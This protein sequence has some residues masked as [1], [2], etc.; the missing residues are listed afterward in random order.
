MSEAEFR[1]E[2]LEEIE[3]LQPDQ[4]ERL[5]AFARE[6]TVSKIPDGLSWEEMRKYRGIISREE[7]E[8][9]KKAIE[10]ECER[11]DPEGW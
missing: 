3:H 7:A 1:H 10:E 9:M 6:L 4:Q 11:I 2:L 5:L 8:A